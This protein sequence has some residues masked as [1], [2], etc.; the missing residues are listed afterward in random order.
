MDGGGADVDVGGGSGSGHFWWWVLRCKNVLQHF[1]TYLVMKDIK[2]I[3]RTR[4]KI[5]SKIQPCLN[6]VVTTC[7]HPVKL[8]ICLRLEAN[9]T[10][11]I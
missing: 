1:T 10:L 11:N 5:D 7:E 4:W 6:F 3:D 2:P 8:P 9:L